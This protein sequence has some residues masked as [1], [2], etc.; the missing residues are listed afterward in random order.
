MAVM[1][2]DVLTAWAHGAPALA[3]LSAAN[4]QG[5]LAFLA[6]PRDLT[7]VAEFS[8]LRQDRV[9][10]VFDAMPAR[11]IV[12]FRTTPAAAQDLPCTAPIESVIAEAEVAGFTL[13][14]IADMDVGR[15]A[16]RDYFSSTQ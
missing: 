3:L 16:L 5:W 4:E 7:A 12:G 11:G 9:R 2:D 15:M 8:G 13:D 14:R 1:A 10:A 6:P